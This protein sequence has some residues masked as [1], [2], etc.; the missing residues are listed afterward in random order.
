MSTWTRYDTA[1]TLIAFVGFSAYITGKAF[2]RPE[3][4][5]TQLALEEWPALALLVVLLSLS[6]LISMFKRSRRRR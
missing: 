5:R 6:G 3:L 2:M 4:T 1:I